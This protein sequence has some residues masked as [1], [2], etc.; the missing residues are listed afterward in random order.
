MGKGAWIVNKPAVVSEVIDGE[1]VVMNLATGNYFSSAGT[2]AHLWALLED[3]ASEESL[4]AALVARFEVEGA[5]AQADVSRFVAELLAASLVREAVPA[6]TSPRPA[7]AADPGRDAYAAPSMS[8]YSDMRDL[9]MFD[10]IHDVAD[11]GWPSLKAEVKRA[12]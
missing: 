1:L 6:E 11:E 10:P 8:V 7:I 12:G 5:T 3:G 9:L 2:G 4:V